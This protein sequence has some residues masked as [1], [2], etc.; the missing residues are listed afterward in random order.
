LSKKT[1]ADKKEAAESIRSLSDISRKKRLEIATA[2]N[3]SDIEKNLRP[4]LGPS[5]FR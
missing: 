5:L 1:S 2:V 4:I 3:A